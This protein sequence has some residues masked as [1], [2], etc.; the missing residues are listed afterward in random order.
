MRRALGTLLLTTLL[1]AGCGDGGDGGEAGD[2]APSGSSSSEPSE[3]TDPSVDWRLVGIVHAT[4]ADG[5]VSARPTPVP[6]EQAVSD[7]SGQFNT[8][9]L[10]EAILGVVQANEPA[11]GHELVAAVISIGCDVPTA[12]TYDDGKVR[13]IKV[14]TP[15][16]ECFASVTSVAILE[17]PA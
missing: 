1:L 15:M 4:A 9:Q 5:E 11:P 13:A 6:D 10:Q 7:F 3:T 8:S 16:P 2:P 12:V 17:V 14:A